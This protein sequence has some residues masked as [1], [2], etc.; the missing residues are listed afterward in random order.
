MSNILTI[1]SEILFALGSY[2]LL[3]LLKT[4]NDAII[5]IVFVIIYLS[6][7][8][9]TVY[10]QSQTVKLVQLYAPE[11]KGSIYDK[12]FQKIWYESCDEAERQLIGIVS[13]RTFIFMNTVFSTFLTITILLG[14]FIPI[15]F[16]CSFFI[17]ILWLIMSFYYGYSCEKLEKRKS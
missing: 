6:A 5:I 9:M 15:G 11:K 8:S 3:N 1:F 2:Q 10:F 14:M 12:N 13:H 7:I 17:G 4:K 16:L